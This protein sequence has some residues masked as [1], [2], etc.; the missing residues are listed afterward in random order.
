VR[1]STTNP[2][3]AKLVAYTYFAVVINHDTSCRANPLQDPGQIPTL[4]KQTKSHYWRYRRKNRS[5]RIFRDIST[6]CIIAAALT[7]LSDR[8]SPE[9]SCGKCPQ[10]WLPR[11]WLRQF[12]P[13]SIQF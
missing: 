2:P 12:M 10:S 3:T 1:D 5:T 13:M 8:A 9:L 6:N 7:C 4:G 11:P